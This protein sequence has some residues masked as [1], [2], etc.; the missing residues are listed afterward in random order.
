MQLVW[1][2][3]IF[4][5]SQLVAGCLDEAIRVFIMTLGFSCHDT[6]KGCSGFWVLETYS[7]II[8]KGR[9]RPNSRLDSLQD[10]Q[11]I[12]S[13]A[14]EFR[15]NIT[16]REETLNCLFHLK[17]SSNQNFFLSPSHL[18]PTFKQNF[19]LYFTES[20]NYLLRDH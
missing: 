20:F 18:I 3:R 12:R 5:K 4:L 8:L 14:L 16:C 15:I 7:N 10:Y 2:E 17:K 19:F 6:G 11:K 9:N 1:E 13:A